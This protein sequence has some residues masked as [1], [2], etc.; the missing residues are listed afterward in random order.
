[1]KLLALA[2]ALTCSAFA[3]TYRHSKT[4]YPAHT[5]DQPIDHYPN[6]GRYEPHTN[7]TFSQRYFFDSS[8]YKPGGPVFLYIGGEGRGEGSFSKMGTGIIQILMQA[9]NG[10][11]VILENRYYGKSYPYNTSTTDEMRFLTIEQTIAD[12]A[13][14]AQHAVFPGVNA[15]LQAPGTPWILYGGSNAGAQTAYSLK[16]YSPLL[17][18]GI[19][20]SGTIKAKHTYVEFYD[21]IQ[22][23]GPQDCI[24]SINAIIDNIDYL[25]AHGNASQIHHMKSIFGLEALK[26]NRDFAMTIAFPL[27]GPLYYP[28]STWQ[29]L[30]WDPAQSDMDFWYFC[31]NVTN[32]DAPH[33]IPQVDYELAPYTNGEPWTNLGNYA[34][35]IKMQLI[36]TC[37]GAP[38]DSSACFGTQDP[39]YWANTTNDKDR[40]YLYTV[41][42]EI[43]SYQ[44]ARLH[45]PTL[46]SRVV[47]ADH[48][49]Q[50]CEWAFPPGQYNKIPPSP[51]LW[52]ANKYGGY[53]VSAPRLAYID[54]DQDVWLDLGYHSHDAPERVTAS[55]EEAYLHPQLLIPGAGHGWDSYGIQ[56]VSAE[57]DFIREAHLWE[58]RIVKKWLEMFEQ[59]K[60]KD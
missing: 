26:D 60:Q 17:W 19:C 32:L 27:G 28:T 42:T 37:N 39:A 8:Y 20:T 54:G 33:N 2:L 40:S 48:T 55:A 44:A 41:C 57:P 35:Y 16:T 7:A 22:K 29:E 3:R 58:I 4:Q 25:F 47:Q 5:I 50:W 18:G 13:Y 1:M 9:T 59:Q 23:F 49:Q 43:G 30:I 11:G 56:N 14:F 21:P 6:S 34:N 12:N 38:I 45:G 15:S 51:E 36:P 46:L 24:G 52:W 53:D 31:R 10:I